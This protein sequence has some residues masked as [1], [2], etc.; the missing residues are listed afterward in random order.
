MLALGA[1]HLT[2]NTGADWTPQTL[3]HRTT[4]LR[5]ISE[6][7]SEP[8]ESSAEG[9]ALM[10]ALICLAGQSSFLANSVHEYVNL[11]RGSYLVS[12][13]VVLPLNGSMFKSI[14]DAR[15]LDL[16]I[17]MFEEQPK[18]VALIE[19]YRDYVE[20]LSKICKEEHELQYQSLLYRAISLLSTKPLDG[21]CLPFSTP[22]VGRMAVPYRHSTLTHWISS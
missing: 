5:L 21:K 4:A 16:L 10:G 22:A 2:V 15:H 20:S 7:L 18:D 3:Y 17:T 6:R 1:S 11:T 14:T 8:I 13:A 9:D 12:Q 19:E